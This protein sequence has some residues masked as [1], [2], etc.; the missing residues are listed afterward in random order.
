MSRILVIADGHGVHGARWVDAVRELGHGVHWVATRTPVAPTSATAVT[1]LDSVG[2]SP[3]AGAVR[4]AQNGARVKDVCRQFR[5]DLVQAQ[6][7][8]PCGWYAW[9]AA[10]HPYTVHLWGSDILTHAQQP[11]HYRWLSARALAGA[12]TVTAD[13]RNLIDL[14]AAVAPTLH[15]GPV[16]SWGVDT[17]TFTPAAP[18][19]RAALKQSLGITTE[20][21]ILCTRNF[22]P[23]MNV[24]VLV[25]AFAQLLRDGEDRCT[26]V[27]KKGFPLD[28]DAAAV[29][30][31]IDASGVA[32]RIVVIETAYGYEQMA[33]LYAAADVIVSIPT[34]GRDGLAHS[35]LDALACGCVPV[36]SRN[37]DTLEL[38][39]EHKARGLVVDDPSDSG[40]VARACA[41]A[42][43]LRVSAPEAVR[44]NRAYIERM[45][46]RRACL[47]RL[48]AS[49][50]ALVPAAAMTR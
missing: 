15:R 28:G 13:S 41:E 34:P 3:L 35:L 17:R 24:P 18:E 32:D 48:S 31:A 21:V 9:M 29:H 44:S 11:P 50:D 14:A 19:R 6:F 49:I 40:A 16:L 46:E 25:D 12:A 45:F 2:A 10:W 22:G 23:T 39:G 7:L 27:L 43:R 8:T 5:P 37:A 38:I 26:L 30:A 4:L 20:H 36:V 33:S 42:L 47:D 1:V